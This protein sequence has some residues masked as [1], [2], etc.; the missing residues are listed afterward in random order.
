MDADGRERQNKFSTASASSSFLPTSRSQLFN[1]EDNDLVRDM[2]A[3][4]AHYTYFPIDDHTG[5][6]LSRTEAYD[7][8]CARL[9]NLQR[10][11]LKHY[12]EKLTV[13]ALSNYGSI[14]SRSELEG[15]LEPLTADELRELAALLHLRTSY[16]DSVRLTIDRKFLLE[17]LLSTF[18]RRRT[19]QDTARALSVLPDEET[20]FEQSL[21]RN[22]HYDGSR[23]L[24]LPKLNL[25]YLSV[26]DFLWRSLVLYRCESFYGIRRDIEDVVR[27]LQPEI[28]RSGETI[29]KGFSRM[30]LPIS[31]PTILEVMPP[32]V[33][34]DFP[35][36]VRA[37]VVIDVKN[38]SEG[39][40]RDWESLR[41]DDVVFLV[42]VDAS[43]IN[44]T[45]NGRG[46]SRA[47]ETTAPAGETS[48][49]PS[50][51]TAIAA[52]LGACS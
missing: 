13:L 49:T 6:Q 33:G 17:V 18:E 36:A 12:K 32:H 10:I 11:A 16:P 1:D 38:L 50:T 7:R 15:L 48:S 5:I 46:S 8:H 34:D 3:V 51:T 21:V 23:P 41:P 27:R 31:K 42:S 4:L 22:D 30:A 28:A 24:A 14:D 2:V 9:A 52:G 26:G 44:G 45:V 35:S 25:Q 47:T 29:F 19:F 40:R 43:Q 20:L 37:E 39:I